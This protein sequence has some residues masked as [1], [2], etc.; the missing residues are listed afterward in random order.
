MKPMIY[1]KNFSHLNRA[2]DPRA[3][4][5]AFDKF[6]EREY[7]DLELTVECCEINRVYH[8]PGKKC[9]I[10]YQVFGND[11]QRQ[12]YTQWFYGVMFKDGE[13]KFPNLETMP[14]NWPG[15]GHWK[16][17]S[18]LPEM[19]MALYAFPYNRKMPYLSQLLDKEFIKGK[20][21]SNLDGFGLQKAWQCQEIDIEKLKYR[22]GKSCVLRY[23]TV[24]Q[25]EAGKR[26]PISFFSK[27]YA[28]GLSKY[29]YDALSA[30]CQ[31]TV[32]QSNVLNIPQPI[33]HIDETNTLWQQEWKGKSLRS[34]GEEFGWGGFLASDLIPKIAQ[35]LAE[36]HC[37]NVPNISLD[38]GPSI[39]DVLTEASDKACLR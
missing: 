34:F 19:N 14:E 22:H 9:D 8:K 20:I 10:T 28:T 16:P 27:T 12:S 38:S 32:Q 29:V 39:E 31:Q 7:P 37:L 21:E 35:M 26:L 25:N 30:I 11:G 4:A 24:L 1:D 36:L 23:H 5:V 33:A 3:M 6:F 13:K 18:I 2:T 15:C 17:F